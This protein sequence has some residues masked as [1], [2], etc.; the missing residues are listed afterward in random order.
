MCCHSILT[1]QFGKIKI[2]N[3]G[4]TLFL[5]WVQMG[6]RQ[7]EETNAMLYKKGFKQC[8]SS[9]ANAPNQ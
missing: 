4:G 5:L 8:F 2:P 6:V 9:P 7:T 1:F 3:F